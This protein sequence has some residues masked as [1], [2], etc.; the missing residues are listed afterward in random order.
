[1][2]PTVATQSR[3]ASLTA[4][5]SVRLPLDL[6]AEHLHPEHVERLALDVDGTHVHLALEA[7]Q[8]GGRRR[9]HAVLAG[10]GLGDEAGLA[11]PLGEQ[12]LAEDVVD[13]VRPGVVEVLALEHDDRLP[14]LDRGAV[15]ERCLGEAGHLGDRCRAP[16]VVLAQ[17]VEFGPELVVLH[18]LVEFGLELIKGDVQGLG[19]ELA[20][21]PAEVT[22]Q[23]GQ[24]RI[25]LHALSLKGGVLS[26][27]KGARRWR[28]H[29]FN[30]LSAAE[31]AV[32]E[33]RRCRPGEWSM[34]G[35]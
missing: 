34:V 5:L 32:P 14:A 15:G 29:S 4:S 33:R 26:L 2:S 25:E 1:V 23:V 35:Y 27:S 6:G 30:P 19:D 17:G 10:A 8:R 22:G 11:H 28:S 24:C 31:I 21:E 9:R 16:G 3:S 7:E 12:R 20:T 18:G 13:L